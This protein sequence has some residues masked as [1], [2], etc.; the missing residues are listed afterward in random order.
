MEKQVT[1]GIWEKLFQIQKQFKTFS[2][3]EDSEK[4]DTK[5]KPAYRYT[6]G[7]EIVEKLRE[8]MDELGLMLIQNV[9]SSNSQPID[10]P[11]YKLINGQPMTFTKKE[12]YVELTNEFTWKDTQTGEEAGPFFIT[13]SG[14][15]GTDKS[16]A[17][18]LAL[19]ERYF[20]LK[21]FRITTREKNDEPDAH[22][23]DT[24]PGIPKEQQQMPAGPF[25]PVAATQE[26]GGT[27]QPRHM[28][29][30]FQATVNPTA[31]PEYSAPPAYQPQPATAMPGAP[32][33]DLR[34]PEILAAVDRLVYFDKGTPTHQ[35]TLN[36][37][38]AQLS[39]RGFNCFVPN[40]IENLTE[41]AQA[42]RENRHPNLK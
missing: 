9:T 37:V 1:K 10:Y 29:G 27:G 14:A 23:C 36:A 22:D 38:M 33:F 13:S 4:V 39:S 20:L 2:A 21:F 6:P 3:S 19:A 26:Q 31:G 41:A 28:K 11:V 15:N 25:Q 16:M 8:K 42:K 5:G 34:N 24:V 7:W 18:A 17:S 30:T 40:F 35:Q 12:I 32:V